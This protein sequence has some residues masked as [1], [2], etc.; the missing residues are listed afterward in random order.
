MEEA[1]SEICGITCEKD[2]I[3]FETTTI[4]TEEINENRVYKGIRLHVAAQ[5]DTAR[6]KKQSSA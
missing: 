5:L 1:F 2:G 6:Q 4:E 3:R